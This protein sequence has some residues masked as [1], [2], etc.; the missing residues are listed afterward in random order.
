MRMVTE[1]GR[2]QPRVAGEPGIWIDTSAQL[3]GSGGRTIRRG[4]L[5]AK[6]RRQTPVRELE[7]EIP[8]TAQE[9]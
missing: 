3:A 2:A 7:T 6:P 1:Q 9:A 4:K 5:T 8:S